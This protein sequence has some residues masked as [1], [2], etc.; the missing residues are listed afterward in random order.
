[1]CY[2]MMKAMSGGEKMITPDY[3]RSQIGHLVLI[4]RGRGTASCVICPPPPLC[5]YPLLVHPFVWNER[6][7]FP[8]F[9]ITAVLSVL[10]MFLVFFHCF[11]EFVQQLLEQV[12]DLTNL[13]G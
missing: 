2:E 9:H 4:D 6:E 3:P 7:D 13:L 11:T 10:I 5:P 1:M 8:V 12:L